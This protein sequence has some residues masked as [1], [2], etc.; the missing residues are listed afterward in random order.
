MT[1]T[2]LVTSWSSLDFS[3]VFE[4]DES[5]LTS[6]RSIVTSPMAQQ[7]L[8]TDGPEREEINIKIKSSFQ[9]TGPLLK[10]LNFSQKGKTLFDATI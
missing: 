6:Y 7:S 3:F 10:Y 4:S 1:L 5:S 8:E 2:L 9:W